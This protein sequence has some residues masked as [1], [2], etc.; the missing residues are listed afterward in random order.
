MI[1]EK[2]IPEAVVQLL[3]QMRKEKTGKEFINRLEVLLSPFSTS[4]DPNEIAEK[5]KII[6]TKE[7]FH[8][9]STPVIKRVVR[10]LQLYWKQ[11]E[12]QFPQQIL[13]EIWNSRYHEYKVIVAK[14]LEKLGIHYPIEVLNFIEARIQDID[15]WDVSDQLAMSGIRQIVF[16]HP[17]KVFPYSQKWVLSEEKWSQRLGVTLWIALV[18][19]KK[20]KLDPVT[21]KPVSEIIDVVIDSEDP[22]V[23]K[24]VSWT[25]RELSKKNFELI[26]DYMLSKTP[27][28]TRN[29]RKT[30]REGAK[31]LPDELKQ[32]LK[33]ALKS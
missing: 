13:D 10:G 12:D 28:K 4:L 8:M 16:K 1:E 33:I 7:E 24:G 15:A 32:K 17:Q 27:P 31:L 20:F 18:R 29:M 23:S 3:S 9:L 2:Q 26:F 30:L 22:D 21:F 11:N 19:D 14:A 6:P 5:R 25:L